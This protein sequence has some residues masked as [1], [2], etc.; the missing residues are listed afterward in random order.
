MKDYI[1]DLKQV[2]Q[3][4]KYFRRVLETGES[5]QVVVM[6]LQ[7]GEEIGSE[8]HPENE[9]V[10]FCLSGMGEVVVDGVGHA[11]SDGDL[12]LVRSGQ[13]HNFINS[14]K[15][16]MKIITIYSPPHHKEGLIHKTKAEA[17]AS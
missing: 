14:G 10:L 12:V 2:A 11:Y 3:D 7:P 15:E 5:M 6:S 13:E 9:Q 17:E 16:E 4:N 8:V 1:E